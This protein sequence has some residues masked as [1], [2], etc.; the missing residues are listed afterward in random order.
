MLGAQLR[1]Q[2]AG[3]TRMLA[4][5]ALCTD[6]QRL[7]RGTIPNSVA[8][9]SASAWTVNRI[10]SALAS[11]LLLPLLHASGLIAMFAVISYHG[12]LCYNGRLIARRGEPDD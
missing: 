10:E 2:R 5:R 3:E 1:R 12:A 7:C 9:A 8:S 11:L 4:L 6:A